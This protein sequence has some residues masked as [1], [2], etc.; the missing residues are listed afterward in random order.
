MG[1]QMT[2][3][4]NISGTVTVKS[5]EIRIPVDEVHTEGVVVI[6]RLNGLPLV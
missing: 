2:I 6:A 3:I 5:K 4:Y 1:R